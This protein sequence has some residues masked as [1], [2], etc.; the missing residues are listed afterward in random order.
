MHPVSY[1]S[2]YC[3]FMMYIKLYKQ[4][5]SYAI[6]GNFIV[7]VYLLFKVS[8]IIAVASNHFLS[9]FTM[10][11]IYWLD[12][13]KHKGWEGKHPEL[14]LNWQMCMLLSSTDISQVWYDRYFF[15]VFLLLLVSLFVF[16]F[17]FWQVS[18]INEVLWN[19]TI[20]RDNDAWGSNLD[21]MPERALMHQENDQKRSQYNREHQKRWIKWAHEKRGQLRNRY[22]FTNQF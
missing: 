20:S 21:W 6:I 10:L 5:I 15:W 3:I 9:H 16:S 19:W 22:W 4:L 2:V 13:L 8:L 17:V 1:L 7:A 12:I 11:I 18:C 14:I